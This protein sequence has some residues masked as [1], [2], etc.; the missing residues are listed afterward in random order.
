M[1]S[2]FTLAFNEIVESRALPREVVL[3]ALSQALVSAYKRDANIGNN[4]RVEAEIDPTGNSR[5]LLEK[6]VVDSVHTDQTEVTLETARAEVPDAQIGDTVM[7]P[8]ETGAS[9]GRIAAQTAKQVILQRIREAERETLYEEFVEREG[10]LVTGTVQSV[11]HSSLTVSLGRA[12]AVM[13]RKEQIPGERYRHHDKVRAYVAEVRKNTRG[14]QI[15]VSRAHK[16]MLRRLLEYEVPEIYNGQVEIKNIAREAGHR[17]KVAVAALQEG[18]DPVGAC[19]GMRGIRIQNI[20]KELNDEKIDVIE[21]NPDPT[22]FI[23]KALSPA[24]VSDMILEDDFDTGR[25]AT[26]VVPDDQLSLAIGREGQNARL[27]A[28][29][30]GW[31]IDIKSVSEAVLEAWEKM[32]EFPLNALH[33][34]D[35]DLIAEVAHIIEKKKANRPIPPEEFKVLTNFA[36]IAERKLLAAREATRYQRRAAMDVVRSVVPNVAFTMDI[37]ELEL[38]DDINRALSRIDNVGDLMIRMLADEQS[39]AQNLKQGGAGDDAMEAI[40]YALDDLVVLRQHKLEANAQPATAVDVTAE[41]E[42]EPEIE[43]EAPVAIEEQAEEQV[44]TASAETAAPAAEEPAT[45]LVPPA[46][47]EDET[48]AAE[49]PVDE[50]LLPAFGDA[51]DIEQPVVATTEE[52][53]EEALLEKAKRRKSEG[54]PKAKPIFDDE[55]EFVDDEFDEDL[56]EKKKSKRK[57]R[58][59]VFDEDRGEVVAKRRRKGSRKRDDWED[60]ID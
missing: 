13:P 59:L 34:E 24:R 43:A 36:K 19:V 52:I 3:E 55:E 40:R 10:D 26:V 6:E 28:K 32:D 51:A 31:R 15:I 48:D 22:I 17:S 47:A 35:P 7:V 11:T 21:W 18:V 44:V 58:Q 12:E 20:V 57:R 54:R 2:D 50:E 9:F 53:D 27:A 38:D 45:E 33:E 4:Q 37:R 30:T 8:V 25:T 56:R 49:A 14:P 16:N 42:A 5:I 1:K 39:L 60:F 23:G 29:L 41:V 46:F